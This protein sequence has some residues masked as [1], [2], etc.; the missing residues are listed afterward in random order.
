MAPGKLGQGLVV[1]Q[2]VP[3]QPRAPQAPS[4]PGVTLAI[5]RHDGALTLAP[6]CSADRRVAGVYGQRLGWGSGCQG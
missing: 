4:R 3:V 2:A 5:W 1:M 6:R